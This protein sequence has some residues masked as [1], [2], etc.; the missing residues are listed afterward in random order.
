MSIFNKLY[1]L[2]PKQPLPSQDADLLVFGPDGPSYVD[3]RE[4]PEADLSDCDDALELSVGSLGDTSHHP[5]I[6]RGTNIY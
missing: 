6:A 3:S 4:F 2:G 5:L 1:I